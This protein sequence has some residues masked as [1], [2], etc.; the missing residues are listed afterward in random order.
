MSTKVVV[1]L[2]PDEEKVLNAFRR[3]QASDEKT[4]AS[5]KLTGDVGEKAGRQLADSF[6]KGG[7]SGTKSVTGLLGE[8]KRAGDVGR[9]VGGQLDN[10]LSG[11]GA[12]GKRS[13]NEIIESMARLQPEAAEQ[14]K[15]MLAEFD[16]TKRGM[17]FDDAL[18]SLTEL[19]DEFK[20][21]A[22]EIRKATDEPVSYTHLTL[23][24]N[25]EV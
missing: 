2:T 14:A 18:S 20:I 22:A 7:A 1:E 4:R 12:G 3:V 11:I 15:M 9:A 25:R 10:Y 13:V 19:G 23:P 6:A 5:L 24:T 21:V 8:L 16:K 17:R